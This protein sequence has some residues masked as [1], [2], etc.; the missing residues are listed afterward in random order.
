MLTRT[1]LTTDEKL[2]LQMIFLSAGVIAVVIIVFELLMPAPAT[3]SDF[4]SIAID[5][6]GDPSFNIIVYS[7]TSAL[8][9]VFSVFFSYRLW[10]G[11]KKMSPS[12]RFATKQ[13]IICGSIIV[14]AAI[15]VGATFLRL[16]IV[17]YSHERTLSIFSHTK[18]YAFLEPKVPYFEISWFSLFPLFLV[19]CGITFAVLGCMWSA[20]K[21]ADIIH[22]Q[23]QKQEFDRD[24]IWSELSMFSLVVAAV[25]LTSTIATT[26]YL[27]L[28]RGLATDEG[29]GVYYKKSADGMTILWA[30]CFSIIMII[31]VLFPIGEMN[32][33][34]RKHHQEYRV[35][36]KD[37]DRFKF[38]YGTLST[39]RILKMLAILFAP[40]YVAIIRA[41]IT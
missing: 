22:N 36:G 19:M 33:A 17:T 4:A 30:A 3:K 39:D 41:A 28:G 29:F 20:V 31:I 7:L 34:A 32:E 10:L 1:A 14:F 2:S 15:L 24:A 38:V 26:F 25:F 12:A 9:I 11:I 35:L 21:A 5:P 27:S 8:H 37:T 40:M 6:Q 13:K 16:D 18:W 23:L